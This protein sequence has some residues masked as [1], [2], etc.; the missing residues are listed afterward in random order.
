MVNE[1]FNSLASIDPKLAV[2]VVSALPFIE[3]RGSVPLGVALG[4]N[5]FE[6][7]GIS[8]IG[9]LA[10]IPFVVIFGRYAI[11]WLEHFKLL[12][13][14]IRKAKDKVVSKSSWI[15]KYGP[16]GLVFIVGIPIPGTGVWTGA[17]LALLMNLRM[18]RAIPAMLV[19][20]II[21]CAIMSIGSF[22]IAGIVSGL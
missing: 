16:W 9:N 19:G 21:A 8:L 11:N 10:P 4:M 3:L 20:L 12:K 17:V 14:P 5:W 6:V 18:K 2:L 7:C 15:K 1:L 22:G 13:K